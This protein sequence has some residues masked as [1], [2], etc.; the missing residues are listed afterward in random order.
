MGKNC[1][2][3]Y[4]IYDRVAEESAPPFMARTDGVAV[5]IYVSAVKSPEFNITDFWLYKVGTYNPDDMLI[6]AYEKAVR[7][8]VSDGQDTEV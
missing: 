8:K 5:R 3:L 1:F 2:G 4:V 7:V 6:N